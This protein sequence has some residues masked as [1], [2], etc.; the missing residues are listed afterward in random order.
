M[1]KLIAFISIVLRQYIL[2]NPVMELSKVILSNTRIGSAY[3]SIA[4]LTNLFI[5][6]VISSISYIMV[7]WVYKRGEAPAMGS[8]FFFILVWVNSELLTL[9]I[10]LGL[11]NYSNTLTF[12]FII[13]LIIIFVLATQILLLKVMK[14]VKELYIYCFK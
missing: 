3:S 6:G 10:N 13:A 4:D 9:S 11:N 12:K 7:G 2:P 14:W 8:V 5:G 1:Y